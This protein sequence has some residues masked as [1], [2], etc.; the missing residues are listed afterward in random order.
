VLAPAGVTV[1]SPRDPA[2]RGAHVALAHPN[3][4]QLCVTLL[5]EGVIVDF[6]RPDVI[7]FGLSPL[8]TRF[9]D[10]WDGVEG[11]RRALGRRG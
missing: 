1:A 8:T 9:V 3:A 4:G 5:D 10:V 11:L 2:R 6:R 7:R